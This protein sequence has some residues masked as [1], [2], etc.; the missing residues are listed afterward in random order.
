MVNKSPAQ[1][2]GSGISPG[3]TLRSG[4]DKLVTRLSLSL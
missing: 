1:E 4:L 3:S 2:S